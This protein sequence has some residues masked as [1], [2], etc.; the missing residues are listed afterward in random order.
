MKNKM[1]NEDIKIIQGIE[2]RWSNTAYDQLTSY[3]TYAPFRKTDMKKGAWILTNS[4]YEH[5]R[6]E[7]IRWDRKL[8]KRLNSEERYKRN[9]E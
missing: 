8:F 9:L 3:T 6:L 2:H 7:N 1:K 5:A 4:G